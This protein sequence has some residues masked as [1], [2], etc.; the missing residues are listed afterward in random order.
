MYDHVR[1][2][3]DLETLFPRKLQ[4]ELPPGPLN[5]LTDVAGTAVN[6]S[7][8]AAPAP[9]GLA[10]MGSACHGGSGYFVI[11]FGAAYRIPDRPESWHGYDRRA[12]YSR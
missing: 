6:W 12:A 2:L 3:A 9:F 1:F 11:A 10:R 7:G 8:C 5:G 4:S